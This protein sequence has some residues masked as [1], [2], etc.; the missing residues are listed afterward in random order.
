MEYSSLLMCTSSTRMVYGHPLST[1][2]VPS[3]SLPGSVFPARMRDWMPLEA[4]RPLKRAL[5][6]RFPLRMG[7]WRAPFP[8]LRKGDRL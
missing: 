6:A 5:E 1:A 2:R 7:L 4:S 3:L 8:S